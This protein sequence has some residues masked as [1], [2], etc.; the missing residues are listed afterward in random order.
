MPARLGS[1]LWRR[2]S[3]AEDSYWDFFVNTPPSD[4]DNHIVNAIQRAPE[5][6][7]FPVKGEV[8][9]PDVMSKQIKELA[10]FFGAALTGVV[11]L[12]GEQEDPF[13]IVCVLP[14]QDDPRT[15]KGIGGQAAVQ[16]GQFVTFN[17]GSFIR[18]MGFRATAAPLD[19]PRLA[20]A[21]ALGSLDRDG[22]LLTQRFGAKVYVAGVIR[23]DIP[24]AADGQATL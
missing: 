5:G 18:E 11:R 8:H 4:P 19:G 20:A 6:N 22:R 1:L 17:L 15:A 21:A 13:A 9:S 23:T 3:A 14:A 12:S 10:R 7:V 2:K 16:K 24:L